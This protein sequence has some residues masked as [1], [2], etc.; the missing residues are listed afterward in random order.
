MKRRLSR[1]PTLLELSWKSCQEITYENLHELHPVY[2]EIYDK[3]VE[4]ARE[5]IRKGLRKNK[6]KII[7]NMIYLT[8]TEELIHTSYR[9]L[10]NLTNYRGSIWRIAIYYSVASWVYTEDHAERILEVIDTVDM[11]LSPTDTYHRCR[12]EMGLIK[13]QET[14]DRGEEPDLAM[15]CEAYLGCGRNLMPYLINL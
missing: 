9:V 3:V 12:V 15:Y 4:K 6:M 13:I 1:V 5:R 2:K 7:L 14:L 8:R 10:G 11:V